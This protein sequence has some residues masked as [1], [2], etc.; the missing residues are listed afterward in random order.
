MTTRLIGAG[1][2]LLV[3]AVWV[4]VKARYRRRRL[5]GTLRRNLRL[6]DLLDVSDYPCP[7][8]AGPGEPHRETAAAAADDNGRDCE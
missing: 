8:G 6:V 3:L 5:Q 7:C 1:L 4:Y 2:V